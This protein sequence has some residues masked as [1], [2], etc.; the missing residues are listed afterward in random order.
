LNGHDRNSDF[1]NLIYSYFNTS[2]S[3]WKKAILSVIVVLPVSGNQL[4]P[5]EETKENGNFADLGL[6]FAISELYSASLASEEI[7]KR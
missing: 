2:I 6:A 1:S 4:G 7:L 3:F 5:T